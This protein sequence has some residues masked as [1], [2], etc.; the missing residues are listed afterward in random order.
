[1]IEAALAQSKG[2]VSGAQGA[3]R[4]LGLPRQTLDARILSPKTSIDRE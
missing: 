1:M 4:G 2:V 3:A